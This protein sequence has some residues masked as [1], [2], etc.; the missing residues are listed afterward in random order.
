MDNKTFYCYKI[1]NTIN[2]KV[3]IGITTDIARRLRQHKCD[4]KKKNR[5]LY[6]SIRK[7]GFDKFNIS[8]VDKKE[9]W[10]DICIVE[11]SI[12]KKLNAMERQYGYNLS[13]GGEG[14]YGV[15][16]SEETKAKLRA[17][18][19]KQMTPEARKHLSLIAKK[20][21]SNPKN[22]EMSRQG[23][24]KQTNKNLSGLKKY[25]KENPDAYLKHGL[26]NAKRCVYNNVE[27]R[28]IAE[29]ARQ[30]N[31]PETTMR[32]KV[33]INENNR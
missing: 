1:T 6:N 8:V 23:A 33:I 28:S 29:A 27:Y 2:S 32:R 31:I 30:N 21:M 5:P 25:Y 26:I 10:A 17:I 15:V 11:M 16:R 22:R 24:L 13:A 4:A 14:A 7:Y 18:T 9:T 12:I 3:Y 19:K 20:Q